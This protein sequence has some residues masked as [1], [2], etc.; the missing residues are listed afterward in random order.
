MILDAKSIP[1]TSGFPDSQDEDMILVQANETMKHG[2]VHFLQKYLFNP[3]IE[4]VFAIGLI[5]PESN[6]A[7]I[8]VSKTEQTAYKQ[9]ATYSAGSCMPQNE[10]N[11]E[12]QSFV[13]QSAGTPTHVRECQGRL[14]SIYR[15]H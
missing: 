3:P 13:T 9:P 4:F 2:I 6:D 14:S 10:T 5:P 11:Q 15:S 8:R 7:Y 12:C 1:L